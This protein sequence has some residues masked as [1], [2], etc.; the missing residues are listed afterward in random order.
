VNDPYEQVLASPRST[1]SRDALARYWRDAKDPRAELIE[2]Q[3]RVH[4]YVP[5]DESYRVDMEIEKL[6]EE[7]GRAWAGQVAEIAKRYSFRLGA[8]SGIVISGTKFVE[9]A[10]QLVA[11]APIIELHLTLP[12]DLASVCRVPQL[13]QIALMSIEGGAWLGDAEAAVLARCPHFTN[14]CEL[15][16]SRGNIGRAGYERIENE[17]D[18]SRIIY[19]DFT[20]NPG[21]G[22]ASG[23]RAVGVHDSMYMVG[24]AGQASLDAA[25]TAMV[26]SYNSTVLEHWPPL[27]DEFLYVP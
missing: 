6:I 24:D 7:H 8:V 20:G 17:M 12:M 14:L 3:L 1:S 23:T 2:R 19:I 13:E 26:S 11:L 21:A 25:Y 5:L 22:P 16:L 15:D 27:P 18:L 4:H 10:A 9:H